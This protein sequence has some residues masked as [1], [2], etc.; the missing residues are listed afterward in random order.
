MTVLCK[1]QGCGFTKWET[2]LC[3]KHYATLRR[4]GV[5]VVSESETLTKE[6]PPCS[7]AGCDSRA[8]SVGMCIT[9]YSRWYRYGDVEA[10]SD[11]NSAPQPTTEELFWSMVDKSGDCW[12]WTGDTDRYGAGR[13]KFDGS[14]RPAHRYSYM[15]EY[16][17]KLGRREML[18]HSCKVSSCVRPEHLLSASE[19]KE[20]RLP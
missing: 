6:L 10:A 18:K 8:F 19:L 11:P 15:Q 1:V 2:G 7:V 9:H 4:S 17:V 3:S 5:L 12:L 16:N 14:V 13:F 20:K